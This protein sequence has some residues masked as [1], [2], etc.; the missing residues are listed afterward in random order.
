MKNH[1]TKEMLLQDIYKN[2]D[3]ATIRI[4]D[5]LLLLSRKHSAIYPSQYTLAGI[6]G[7]CRK[8]ANRIIQRLISLDLITIKRRFNQS[9]V[10][11]INMRIYGLARELQHILP[12][13]KFMYLGLVKSAISTAVTLSRNIKEYIYNSEEENV[14]TPVQK[15]EHCMKD[16]PFSDL[17]YTPERKKTPQKG[18]L[19]NPRAWQGHTEPQDRDR[20]SMA[21]LRNQAWRRYKAGEFK[22]FETA[23]AFLG[24]K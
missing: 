13:L 6:A 23:C 19:A 4:L 24:V 7:V 11:T 14:V 3:Y 1:N 15:K 5:Y 10:Y 2:S 18:K 21:E 12:S 20:K 9:N 8:T 22:D 17:G 16:N